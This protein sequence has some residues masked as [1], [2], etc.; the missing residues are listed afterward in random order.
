MRR[1]DPTPII[2]NFG[3]LGG[4][5]QFYNILFWYIGKGVFVLRGAENGQFLYLMTTAI[6]ADNAER[7]RDNTAL[8]TRD[9]TSRSRGYE[10]PFD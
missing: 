8:D 1:G 9:N 3:L 4:L 7:Y 6:N 5:N 2:M 10:L